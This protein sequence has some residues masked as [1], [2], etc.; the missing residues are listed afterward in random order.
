MLVYF[1][2]RLRGQARGYLFQVYVQP[3]YDFL[4]RGSVL[5]YIRAGFSLSAYLDL[6]LYDA[7]PRGG[8]TTAESAL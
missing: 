8:H 7:G 5:K 3:Q 2:F 1:R 4:I 6:Q